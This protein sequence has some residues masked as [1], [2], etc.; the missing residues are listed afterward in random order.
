MPSVSHKRWPGVGCL[1]IP[2]LYWIRPLTYLDY[3]YEVILLH[4]FA[5][6]R[7]CARIKLLHGDLAACNCT[8]MLRRVQMPWY[9]IEHTL[10]MLC[11]AGL[12]YEK[13]R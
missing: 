13:N 10:E 6:S 2:H 5:R 7:I 12:V 9:W 8:E 11:Q 3:L 1:A 4:M